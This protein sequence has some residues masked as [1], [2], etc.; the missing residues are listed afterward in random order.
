MAKRGKHTIVGVHL[1]DR[2]KEAVEV[3]KLFTA[4]GKQIK[5]RLG[6]HEV[7]DA[8]VGLNGLIVLEMVGLEQG[9]NELVTKLNAIAGVEAKTLLFDH[10]V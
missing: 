4:Y 5:T 6:L 10:P 2:V 9:I 8:A 7:D 1:T 3:Q